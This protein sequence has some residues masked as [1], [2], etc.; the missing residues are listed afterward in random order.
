MKSTVPT[1]SALSVSRVS[2]SSARTIPKSLR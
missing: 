2:A 1:H